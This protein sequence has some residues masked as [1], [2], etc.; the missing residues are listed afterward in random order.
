M[1][2]SDFFILQPSNLLDL[3]SCEDVGSKG[4]KKNMLEVGPNFVHFVVYDGKNGSLK[5]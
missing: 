1:F 4:K 2:G 5:M 3:L